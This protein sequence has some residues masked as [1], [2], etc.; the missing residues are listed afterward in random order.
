MVGR[1]VSEQL[2]DVREGRR[3]SGE[4]TL[5]VS[6]NSR[7][8]AYP[9]NVGNNQFFVVVVDRQEQKQYD[10][11]MGLIVF[12]PDS[13]RIA[14]MALV[15]SRRL[16][17]ARVGYRLLVVVDG[18]EGGQYDEISLGQEGRPVFDSPDQLHYIARKGNVIYLVEEH[19]A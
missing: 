5:V 7:R 12:S 6:P 13:H 2:I 3:Y 10:G 18:V 11:I 14:Y 1:T 17:F 16:G 4:G 8:V 9:E 15:I 19:L